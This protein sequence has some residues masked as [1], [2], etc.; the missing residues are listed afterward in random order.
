MT[1]YGQETDR[2]LAREAGFDH[3]WSSRSISGRSRDLLT[4]PGHVGVPVPGRLDED[5]RKGRR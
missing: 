5:G 1:G 3:T 2:Q 4:T